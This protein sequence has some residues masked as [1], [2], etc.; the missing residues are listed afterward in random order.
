MR[1]T[2]LVLGAAFSIGLITGCNAQDSD[3]MTAFKVF[4]GDIACGEGPMKDDAQ[5]SVIEKD[6]VVHWRHTARTK[7]IDI[8]DVLFKRQSSCA[9][10]ITDSSVDGTRLYGV[11]FTHA[12]DFDY[13]PLNS[14]S[15]L[16]PGGTDENGGYYPMVGKISGVEA[17]KNAFNQG[18]EDATEINIA[19]NVKAH[20]ADEAYRRYMDIY[21][22]FRASI[23]VKQ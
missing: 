20:N 17:W 9:Y 11:D 21:A 18:R 12:G 8:E 22:H 1:T 4:Y 19:V 5:C 10:K 2:G 14:N 6:D 15:G 23:C 13:D 7:P 3:V 16:E